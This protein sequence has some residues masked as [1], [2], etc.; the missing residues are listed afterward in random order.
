M[1]GG[2]ARGDW[3]YSVRLILDGR[4][5]TLAAVGSLNKPVGV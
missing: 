1:N 5:N 3:N 2:A 4:K